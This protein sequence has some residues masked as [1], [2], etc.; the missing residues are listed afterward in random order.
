L[1]FPNLDPNKPTSCT[2]QLRFSTPFLHLLT[3]S[4][5][6][7][8]ALSVFIVQAQWVY[9]LTKENVCSQLIHTKWIS[10]PPPLFHER[11]LKHKIIFSCRTGLHKCT[12]WGEIILAE[13]IGQNAIVSFP[14][15]TLERQ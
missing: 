5:F 14:P 4:P 7:F 2:W 9:G 13:D 10:H 11:N 15:P 3:V 8:H 6:L 12:C 1:A